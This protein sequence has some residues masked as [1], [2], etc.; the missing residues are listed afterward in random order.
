LK[1]EGAEIMS[2][3]KIFYFSDILCVW[4]YAAQARLEQI[5]VDFGNKVKILP[6]YC[7]VFADPS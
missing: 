3:V 2:P 1:H 7:S 6:H 4:A 5:E